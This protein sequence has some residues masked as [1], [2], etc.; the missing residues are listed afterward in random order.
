MKSKVAHHAT[1][2]AKA[3]SRCFENVMLGL[4]LKRLSFAKTAEI[5]NPAGI[6]VLGMPAANIACTPKRILSLAIEMELWR[7]D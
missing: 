7:G 4:R 6:R 5:D 1:V 3:P 2:K